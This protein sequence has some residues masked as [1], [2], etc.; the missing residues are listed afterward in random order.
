[1]AND[2]VVKKE[3]WIDGWDISEQDLDYPIAGIGGEMVR[4]T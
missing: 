2:G 4:I 3:T 1:M